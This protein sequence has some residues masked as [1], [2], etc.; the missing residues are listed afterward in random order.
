MNLELPGDK[1]QDTDG[2]PPEED[3]LYFRVKNKNRKDRDSL[4]SMLALLEW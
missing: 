3:W 4:L 2:V 1:E